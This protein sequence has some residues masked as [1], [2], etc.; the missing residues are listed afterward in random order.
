MV[1]IMITR[2][3]I[4]KCARLSRIKIED[5]KLDYMVGQLSRI[6]QMIDSLNEV[7]TDAVKPLTSVLETNLRL[8]DDEV[9]EQNIEEKLFMNVPGNDA[10]FA[11]EI[12]CFIVPKVIE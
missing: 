7:N 9:L 12:K 8:R 4:K 2:E 6:M 1:K 10:E 3:D 5:N 11:R